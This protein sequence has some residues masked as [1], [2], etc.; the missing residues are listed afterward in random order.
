MPCLKTLLRGLCAGLAQFGACLC[1]SAE[2][3]NDR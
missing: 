1:A 2:V 3:R